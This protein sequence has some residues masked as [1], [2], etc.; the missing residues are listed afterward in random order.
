MKKSDFIREKIKKLP[1][2]YVF[3]YHDFLIE[4][5]EKE[6]IIK[7]LNRMAEKGDI[8]KLSKGKFYKA[9]QT[10]FGALLPPQEQ[11]VKDLLY[12]NNKVIGYLT[13]LSIYPTLG[14]TTQI[15]YTIQIG[16]NKTRPKLQREF[17]II[18]FIEQKNIITEYNIPLL[19]FL[20]CI[21]Y[22]KKIPDNNFKSIIKRLL[23]LLKEFDEPQYKNLVRLAQK[24]PPSTRALLGA[25]LDELQLNHL[26]SDLNKSLNPI[27]EYQFDDINE[28]LS[29]AQKWNIK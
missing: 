23:I 2:G 4:E 27:T 29:Y 28:I 20:D 16:T 12:E 17:Y 26:S 15:S 8:C 21:K 25:L 13:G 5:K 10:P 19:Q 14:L 7:A 18:H 9:E 6:A 1:K 24:Y 22:I 11:I 3:T